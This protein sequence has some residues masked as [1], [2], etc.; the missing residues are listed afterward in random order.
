MSVRR[1]NGCHTEK[2]A[3][4]KKK[5]YGFSSS[6]SFEIQNYSKFQPKY[7]NELSKV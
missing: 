4:S 1:K 5:R 2:A 6:Q 7:N 3:V